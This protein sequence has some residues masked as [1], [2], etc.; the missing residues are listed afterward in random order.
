MTIS[1][2]ALVITGVFEGGG[3]GAGS[4]PSKDEGFLKKWLGR[5]AD[6]LKRLAGKAVEALHAIVE[7]VVG[8]ILSFPRKAVGFV[9]EHTGP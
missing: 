6:A 7:S 3:R 1:T 2:I 9:T 8:T 4:P 5:L